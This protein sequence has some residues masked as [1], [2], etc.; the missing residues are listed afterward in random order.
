[1]WISDTDLLFGAI[2]EDSMAMYKRKEPRIF[3]Q[4]TQYK[5]SYIKHKILY[6]VQCVSH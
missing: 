1:M 4:V 6:L 3:K 2:P 5:E